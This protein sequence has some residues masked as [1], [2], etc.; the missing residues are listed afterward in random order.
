MTTNLFDQSTS[1]YEF[2]Y[3]DETQFVKPMHWVPVNNINAAWELDDLWFS[4]DGTP[5]STSSG[6]SVVVGMFALIFRN[7]H[8][9]ATPSRSKLEEPC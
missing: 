8:Q 7:H 2:G 9:F 3:I 5:T 6:K 1:S 4:I